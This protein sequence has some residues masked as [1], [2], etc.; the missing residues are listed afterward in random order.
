MTDAPDGA[1]PLVSITMT[2]YNYARFLPRAIESILDQTFTDYELV[3]IDN[4]STDGSVAV[5]ERY[6]D[7]RIRLIAHTVNQGGL[8]SFRESCDVARGTYRLH[9][10]ADDWII[11]R[12]AVQRQVDM[13]SSDPEI[14]LV[15]GRMT[16][17]DANGE[18]SW[19]SRPHRADT[20]LA[21]EAALADIFGFNFGHSGLMFRLDAYRATD[22]YPDDMPHIDDLVL[23][24]RLAEHGKVGYIDAELYAFS[25]HGANVHMSPNSAVIRDEILPMIAEAFDGPL[26]GRLPDPRA[27]RRRIERRALLHLPTAYIFTDRRADGWRLFWQSVRERPLLTIAQPRTASLVARTLLGARGYDATVMRLRSAIRRDP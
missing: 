5:I 21:G 6:P 19:V 7:P 22:G 9:I 24:A 23:A 27:E 11:E 14:V 12:D 26:A 17:F 1:P 4:A 8:A 18:K 20:V 15:F 3:I 25:Q 2:N 16:M 10:D 13:M